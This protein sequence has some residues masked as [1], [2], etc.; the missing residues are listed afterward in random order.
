M[1]DD[2]GI[3]LDTKEQLLHTEADEDEPDT[4]FYAW[5]CVSILLWG[6][7]TVDFVVK[8]NTDLMCL[9]HVLR[10]GFSPQS[11]ASDSNN[12]LSFYR[13]QKFRMKLSYMA[14]QKQTS[15]IEL[16]FN[17]LLKSLTELRTVTVFKFQKISTN[18]IEHTAGQSIMKGLESKVPTD[19]M[20]KRMQSTLLQH[21]NE[22]DSSLES[23]SSLEEDLQFLSMKKRGSSMAIEA[24]DTLKLHICATK[25]K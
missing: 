6:E 24:Q 4:I 15:I 16:W 3:T 9:L 20:L 8:D 1:N 5:Q 23:E 25:S 19:N 12:S 13:V 21:S 14:R 17:A 2:V 11:N 7:T 18:I 10:Q 22:L